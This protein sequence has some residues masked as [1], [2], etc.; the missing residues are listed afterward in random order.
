M[1]ARYYY[2]YSEN[3]VTLTTL[4]TPK[5][6]STVQVESLHWGRKGREGHLIFCYASYARKREGTYQT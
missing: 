6:L 1:R 4:T 5:S 2:A 3:Q